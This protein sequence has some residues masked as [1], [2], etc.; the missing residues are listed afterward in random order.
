VRYLY[1]Q[2]VRHTID[3]KLDML[4]L[5]PGDVKEEVLQGNTAMVFQHEYDHLDGVLF[6]DKLQP[7]SK[8]KAKAHL[9]RLIRNYGRGGAP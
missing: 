1:L 3:T 5:R 8:I 6:I 4:H 9:A 2:D 7:A